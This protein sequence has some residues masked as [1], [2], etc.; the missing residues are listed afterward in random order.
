MRKNFATGLLYDFID[1]NSIKNNAIK[2]IKRE[3][4]K[5]IKNRY[6]YQI[7]IIEYYKVSLA[8]EFIKKYDNNYSKRE[9]KNGILANALYLLNLDKDTYVLIKAGLYD[10]FEK[11]ESLMGYYSDD[12]LRDKIDSSLHLYF[13]GKYSTKYYYEL[14]AKIKQNERINNGVRRYIYKVSGRSGFE[15]NDSFASIMSTLQERKLDSLYFS[16]SEKET[17]TK[18][19]DMFFNNKELYNTRQVLYK[20]G[21]LL[22]GDPGTGKSSLAKA[23]AT[24][25]NIDMIMVDMTTFDKINI[26][27]LSATLNADDKTYIVLLEDIDTIFNIN[28][29]ENATIDDKKVINKLLQFLDSNNSPTNV[30]F[31][32]TTNHI[33]ILDPALL[34][35]GRFDKKIK[36]QSLNEKDASEMCRSFG[37]DENTISE[38]MANFDDKSNINQ[39]TL[40]SY[41]LS[42]LTKGMHDNEE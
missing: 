16:N 7:D 26:D 17:I 28:R 25:Y 8:N 6:G 13:F 42:S 39:A 34:R 33:D 32:A 11:E 40:Q 5:Y 27:E 1:I 12:N 10:T 29:D 31:I 41:I 14:E 4:S 21:I 18:H 35:A 38:I 30:I 22:Y 20:T 19:I 23:L 24:E 2:Y 3:T 37:S 36:V 9:L 15:G